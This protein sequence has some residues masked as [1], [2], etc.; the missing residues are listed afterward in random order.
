MS[1]NE[2]KLNVF[3][4]MSDDEL[5]DAVNEMAVQL[6]DANVALRNK[7]L[8]GLKAAIEARKEAD[9]DVAE[10]LKRLGYNESSLYPFHD[11]NDR[12]L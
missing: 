5:Q 7:K 12:Y 8:S 11:L 4:S 1:T 6:R 9:A 3:E 10:E 2:N